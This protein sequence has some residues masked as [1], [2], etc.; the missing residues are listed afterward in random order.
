MAK[1]KSLSFGDVF[2]LSLV[3]I[4]TVAS[5]FGIYKA[6][7]YIKPITSEPS[8]EEPIPGDP[9]IIPNLAINVLV[10]GV[11]SDGYI[12]FENLN[13]T[14]V[15][16]LRNKTDNSFYK[17]KVSFQTA[18]ENSLS[19][20]DMN[21]DDLYVRTEITLLAEEYSPVK[22]FILSPDFFFFVLV[23]LKSIP[24]TSISFGDVTFIQ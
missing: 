21:G 9:S 13:D 2:I 19:I 10:D 17:Q 11:I 18:K 23:N 4:A 12:E 3:L 8:S 20:T 14:K 16:E 22:V 5:V 1:R 15:I 6:L 24:A 7:E